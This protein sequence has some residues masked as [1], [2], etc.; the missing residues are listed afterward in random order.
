MS[1]R[2]MGIL[3]AAA[4]LICGCEQHNAEP[5]THASQPEPRDSAPARSDTWAAYDDAWAQPAADDDWSQPPASSTATST[6]STGRAADEPLTP[7]R[8]GAGRTHV[9]A[10]GD[11]LYALARRYYG[12][13]SRW[14]DIYNANRSKLRS[15][16]A[17]PVGTKL[18]IP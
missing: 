6:G 11:T 18:V 2:W 3:V 4:A 14:K 12:D 5:Q 17:L 9:V 1:R 13:Q 16:D 8:A 7:T 10:K 15:A